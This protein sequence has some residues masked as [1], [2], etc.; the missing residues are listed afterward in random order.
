MNSCVITE[1]AITSRQTYITYHNIPPN[2]G[3]LTF[4]CSNLLQANLNKIKL[5]M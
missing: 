3:N 4:R 1:T 5:N 2:T